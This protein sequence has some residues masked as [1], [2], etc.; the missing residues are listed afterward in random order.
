MICVMNLI[1]QPNGWPV[2]DLQ[3]V[4]QCPVCDATQRCAWRTGLTDKLFSAAPGRWT[5]WLCAN[6]GCAYLDPRPTPQSIG[7]AYGTYYTHASEPGRHF[8][9]PGDQPE[10]RAK[11]AVHASYYNRRLGHSLAPALPLGWMLIGASR[12]RRARA[13]Q[14][15]RHL[16]APARRGSVL[17]D[18][19]CGDGTFMRVARALG[20]VSRGIELDPAAAAVA[21][22]AGFEVDIRS[23]DA[24][25]IAANSI[26]QVTMNH[27]IEHL[28]D[29]IAALRRILAWLRPGGRIWLQTP[30]IDGQGASQFGADWRGLEP[31]RHMVL[32]NPASL[33]RALRAAGYDAVDLLPPPPDASFYI[34][35]S[36]ALRD[37]RDPYVDVGP[38]AR[39]AAKRLGEQWNRMALREPESAES[40]TLVGFKPGHV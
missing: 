14:S 24:V 18:V 16:A 25:E 6:C 19:G 4:P 13:G 22:Q 9:V 38:R 23:I 35:Q 32:F 27:V 8:V 28:H 3:A 37:S 40:V 30:N 29:P 2:G 26:D 33:Q 1:E 10:L 11:R 5:L 20:Y 12:R 15:I 7:R 17:L 39:R 21:R 31:P 36:Q 34:A